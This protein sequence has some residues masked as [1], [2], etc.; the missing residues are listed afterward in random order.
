MILG[1]TGHRPASLPGSYSDSTNRALLNT[2]DSILAQYKPTKVISGMALGWD[3]AVAQT[4]IN[5]GI[6]LIAAIPFKSQSLKWPL[7]SQDRYQK[8]LNRAERIEIISSGDY[9]LQAMQ[10]R[11]QWIV[12][13][14]DLLMAL[15]HQDKSGT[16][17]CIDYALAIN[18]PTFN[19]WATFEYFYH[20]Y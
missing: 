17:N 12:D 15:W 5:R 16:K 1:F 10:Q 7:H 4:V 20:Q 9:S 6:G 11:N 19:C 3:T 8:L 13:R 2:A 14:C 18:R